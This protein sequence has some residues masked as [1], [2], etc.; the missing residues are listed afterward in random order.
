M[1][2]RHGETMYAF[3]PLYHVFGFAVGFLAPMHFGMSI[4]LQPTINPN[5]ILQDFATYKP[6]IIPAVPKLFEIKENKLKYI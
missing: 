4:L 2:L 5:A 1:F 6:Q 3:L